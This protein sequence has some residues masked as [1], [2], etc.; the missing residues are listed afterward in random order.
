MP[1]TTELTPWPKEIPKWYTL[2]LEQKEPFTRQMDVYGA[3]LTYTDH[4]IG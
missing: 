4:E 3:Y 1:E 2:D